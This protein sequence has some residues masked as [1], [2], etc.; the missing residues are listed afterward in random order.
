MESLGTAIPVGNSIPVPNVRSD[1]FAWARSTWPSEATVWPP[2]PQRFAPLTIATHVLFSLFL[3]A[4]LAGILLFLTE[5]I[6][7]PDSEPTRQL[8]LGIIAA[9]II[10]VVYLI[11]L[12]RINIAPP[13]SRLLLV[14]FVTSAIGFLILGVVL[15]QTST[16][17]LESAI[18]P[19]VADLTL[20]VALGIFVLLAM[21]VSSK[22]NGQVSGFAYWR[23]S[24]M[25][26]RK[27]A[28][29][30]GQRLRRF[31]SEPAVL[32][33]HSSELERRLAIAEQLTDPLLEQLLVMP[34]VTV[35]KGIVFPGERT[36]HVGHALVAGNHIALID[37][38][39]WAPGVYFLDAWNRVVRDH[40]VDEDINVSTSVAARRYAD[41]RPQLNIRSWAVVHPI[42]DGPVSVDAHP[43]SEVR[44]VTPE[45]LLREVG[46]WVAPVGE[47]IDT[48][49]LQFLINS[50][51]KK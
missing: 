25:I 26:A 41:E 28:F 48:F 50:R 34:G 39:L 13:V 23:T 7:V 15:V 29:P 43:Q 30:R 51:L 37:S 9:E 44:L 2:R 36:A 10:V 35:V 18:I 31:F 12:R 4:S 22:I 8:V 1:N 33:E 6:A 45:E 20:I 17:V 14:I 21:V 19:Q 38:F 42:V 47:H 32:G 16:E 40:K 3:V 24:V 49:A 5:F 11:L 46:E 27:T